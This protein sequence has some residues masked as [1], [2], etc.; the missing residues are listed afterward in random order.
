MYTL[1]ALLFVQRCLLCYVFELL[2][3]KASWV[4]DVLTCGT[5]EHMLPSDSGIISLSSLVT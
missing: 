1:V 2:Q 3:T 4:K 5:R